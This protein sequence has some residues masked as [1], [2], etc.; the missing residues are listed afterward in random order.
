MYKSEV[1]SWRLS[2]RLKGELEAAARLERKSVAELLDKIAGDWL[3]A[4][5]VQGEDDDTRQQRL[6]AA[7]GR[8]IGA[9]RGGDP[10][11]AANAASQVRARIARRHHHAR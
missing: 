2:P 9:I 6:H 10:D 8:A 1:Y 3:A 11:R 7:A 4:F 5:K